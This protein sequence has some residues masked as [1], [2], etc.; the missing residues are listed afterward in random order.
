MDFVLI[1]LAVISFFEGIV[2]FKIYINYFFVE[3][4]KIV[5]VKFFLFE[6][7]MGGVFFLFLF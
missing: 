6:F 2:F 3:E 7:K 1:I 4:N 5:G